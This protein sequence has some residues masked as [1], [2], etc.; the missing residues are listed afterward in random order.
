MKR[1]YINHQLYS[2]PPK[3]N[4]SARIISLP[5]FIKDKIDSLPH[6][7]EIYIFSFA[8]NAISKRFRKLLENNNLQH[9]RFHDLRHA[10]ASIMLQLGIPDKYA[11][12]TRRM[13]FKC[14][15]EKSISTDIHSR[16]KSRINKDR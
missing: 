13:G 9:C 7:D 4:S 6:K 15:A 3:T 10:N 14:Y 1:V 8:P 16:T 5:K 2:K 12:G 11:N